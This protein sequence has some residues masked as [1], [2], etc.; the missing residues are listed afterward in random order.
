M[1]VTPIPFIFRGQLGPFFREEALV[2]FP[3]LQCSF[4]ICEGEVFACIYISYNMIVCMYVDSN[5]DESC[6][7]V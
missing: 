7:H 3:L 5:F 2:A 4:C 6:V 1:Y